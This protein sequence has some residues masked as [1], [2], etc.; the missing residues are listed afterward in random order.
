MPTCDIQVILFPEDDA[1]PRLFPLKFRLS[2]RTDRPG[3]FPSV[4]VKGELERVLA[5]GRATDL[6]SLLDCEYH[7]IA[8][9]MAGVDSDQM[10]CAYTPLCATSAFCTCC[11]FHASNAHL[12]DLFWVAPPVMYWEGAG[13]QSFNTSLANLTN[14][15]ARQ[16]WTRN[17]IVIKS[18]PVFDIWQDAELE[19]DLPILKRYLSW[20]P[21]D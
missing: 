20:F 12:L 1:A 19:V 8:P 2:E 5:N 7:M 9:R 14:G 16:G 15:Q 6:P 21:G 4:W 11:V 10:Y 17:L 13:I 3:V 18:S